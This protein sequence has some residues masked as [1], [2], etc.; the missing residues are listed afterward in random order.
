MERRSTGMYAGGIAMS[1]VGSMGF[2]GGV[3]MM[4][5][6]AGGDD[7]AICKYDTSSPASHYVNCGSMWAGGGA[8][9]AVGSMLLGGGIALAVIGNKRVP[10]QARLGSVVV[11]PVLTP[12][13]WG[14]QGT[15]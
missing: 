4:V 5:I 9:L 10:A 2:I 1:V 3:V 6:A 11:E 15:F 13:H 7:M 14:L 12:T 8:S